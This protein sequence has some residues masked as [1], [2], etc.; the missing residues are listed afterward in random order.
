MAIFLHSSVELSFSHV[1]IQYHG[2]GKWKTYQTIP[3][4]FVTLSI[5][6]RNDNEHDND[7]HDRNHYLDTVDNECNDNDYPCLNPFGLLVMVVIVGQSFPKGKKNLE[8][9]NPAILYLKWPTMT[10]N[11][12]TF[13][14]LIWAMDLRCYPICYPVVT[15]LL[16]HSSIVPLLLKKGLYFVIL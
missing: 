7:E 8:Q 1:P 10:R 3:L 13:V 4:R 16:P 5:N 11:R 12:L 15:L 14:H 6:T 2:Y 9:S